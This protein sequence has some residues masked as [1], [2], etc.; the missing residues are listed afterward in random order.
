[1]MRIVRC[2]SL[3]MTLLLLIMPQ[4][5]H[6]KD[7]TLL[8]GDTHTHSSYSFDAFL[9]ANMTADPDTAYRFAKGEPVLHP[10]HRARVQ[11]ARP[12]DFLVVADHAEG[13]GVM[14]I[15]Y[16]GRHG[17][18][19]T[20]GVFDLREAVDSGK[21]IEFFTRILPQIF[22]SGSFETDNPVELGDIN[23]VIA[24]GWHDSVEM[25]DKHNQPGKFTTFVGWE[26]SAYENGG[27]MHRVVFSP[28]DAN[29]AK[30][31]IP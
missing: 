3:M 20:S 11:L 30:T 7:N 2:F 19:E 4:T 8:W 24:H 10:L 17:I 6:A 23:T 15:L 29:Q 18:K 9:S 28:I 12:L 31:I 1:M 27:N 14:D 26:W 16:Y 5:T 13:L 21:A 22:P 25:A